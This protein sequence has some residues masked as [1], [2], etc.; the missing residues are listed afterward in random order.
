M[1]DVALTFEVFFEAI[2]EIEAGVVGAEIDSERHR[3]E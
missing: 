1:D 3:C 2:F